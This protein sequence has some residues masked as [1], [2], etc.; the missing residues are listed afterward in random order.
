VLRMH[1]NQSWFFV[2]SLGW[3]ISP[4]HTAGLSP[5][6][7]FCFGLEHQPSPHGWAES[8]PVFCRLEH[9]LNPRGSAESSPFHFFI[10]LFFFFTPFCFVY[11]IIIIIIIIIIYFKVVI[12]AGSFLRHFD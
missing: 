10:F 7:F 6:L 11:F 2:F 12:F 9:Q 1:N 8:S 3:N 4:A 5:A